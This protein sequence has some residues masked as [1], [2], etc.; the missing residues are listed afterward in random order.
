MGS[1]AIPGVSPDL[2]TILSQSG[3]KFGDFFSQPDL[4]SLWMLNNPAVMLPGNPFP[5]GFPQIPTNF[6]GI[7]GAKQQKDDEFSG[8]D[9]FGQFGGQNQFNL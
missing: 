3:A 2:S 7:N 6:N 1:S 8:L 5:E 9:Q 4:A